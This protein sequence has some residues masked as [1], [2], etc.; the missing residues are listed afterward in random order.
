MKKLFILNF[1]LH[2]IAGYACDVCGGFFVAN[3]NYSK[4]Q[5]MLM[6]RYR[7][8]NGY[9]H[10]Q[11]K[12]YFVNPGAYRVMHPEPSD[13]NEAI[14]NY[15][16]KDYESFKSY[17]LK[18]RFTLTN[19]LEL[20]VNFGFQEIRTEYDGIKKKNAGITDLQILLGYKLITAA[21]EN[22]K[23]QLVCGLGAKFPT[24]Q[25]A[26]KADGIRLSLLNQNGSGSFDGMIYTNYKLQFKQLGLNSF[27]VLKINT[28]NSLHQKIGNSFN[29]TLALYYQFAKKNKS[30]FLTGLS[31]YEYNKGVYDHDNLIPST[32]TNVCL[33]GPS[34]D[35]IYKKLQ[36]NLGFQFRVFERN[37]ANNMAN[38]GR[39]ISS[40]SWNF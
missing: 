32:G 23:Q 34:V 35:F 36:F 27:S 26:K 5:V 8:L 13:S 7:V 3:P 9:N 24:G 29:Q 14:T 11:Q 1:I 16:S 18:G 22:F 28:F 19:K 6:H 37:A 38:A 12:S 40:V 20:L 15:S 17:D 4:H 30:V 2:S 39:A 33:L 10:Y 21:S 25:Y 31:T